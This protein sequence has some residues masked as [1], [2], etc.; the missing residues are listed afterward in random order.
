MTKFKFD[1]GDGGDDGLLEEL[2]GLEDSDEE[3]QVEQK[4]EDVKE[5]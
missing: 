3:E 5:E 2:G 1:A 4:D